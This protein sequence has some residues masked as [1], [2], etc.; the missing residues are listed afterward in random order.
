GSSE[1][2]SADFFRV[3][4]ASNDAAAGEG[5]RGASPPAPGSRAAGARSDPAQGH[6]AVRVPLREGVGGRQLGQEVPGGDP[7][8][9]L[10]RSE[11]F[12]PAE[13]CHPAR[14]LDG[15]VRAAR[16]RVRFQRGEDGALPE[17]ARRI[18][19]GEGQRL[20][21]LGADLRGGQA[22]GAAGLGSGAGAGDRSAERRAGLGRGA[23]GTR[24]EPSVD[25]KEGKWTRPVGYTLAGAAV[26]A[27]GIGIFEGQHSKNLVSDAE[28]N[29][30]KNGVYLS[31]DIS[32]LNSA[33]S[34]AT[35]ANVL[36]ASGVVLLAAG[37][38]LAFA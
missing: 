9:V 16:R 12:V 11:G 25:V 15:P 26:L 1:A 7:E 30:R 4:Y 14:R 32:N 19:G 28:S 29:Y 13:G 18:V 6:L 20:R 22:A 17:R 35:I 38:V 2:R 27:L 31:S 5:G 33:K 36:I 10:R 8:D 34:A 24:P 37:G 23:G 21:A 3:E